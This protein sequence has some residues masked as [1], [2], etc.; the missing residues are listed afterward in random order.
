MV[1]KLLPV[2]ILIWCALIA[3]YIWPLSPTIFRSQ[4]RVPEDV[5]ERPLGAE[6]KVKAA[7]RVLIRRG[8]EELAKELYRDEP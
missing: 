2:F 8:I 6:E 7:R 5:P 4:A 1:L 3:N